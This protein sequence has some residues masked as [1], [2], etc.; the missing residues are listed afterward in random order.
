MPAP[1]GLKVTDFRDHIE[2][3]SFLLDLMVIFDIPWLT[4]PKM[5]HGAIPAPICIQF[6]L[7]RDG[8]FRPLTQR[9]ENP[10]G[11]VDP[12]ISQLPTQI[13]YCPLQQHRI[14]FKLTQPNI[15]SSADTTTPTTGLVT[16]IL[17]QRLWFS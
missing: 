11:C 2:K 9:W 1:L 6:S 3:G 10:P 8:S 15:A 13:H 12:C 7:M 5:R 17:H 16:V 4:A 14:I